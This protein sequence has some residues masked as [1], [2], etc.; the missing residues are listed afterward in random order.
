MYCTL[1]IPI[2]VHCTCT[3]HPCPYQTLARD[4]S[5]APFCKITV[6]IAIGGALALTAAR[7]GTSTP[8]TLSPSRYSHRRPGDPPLEPTRL[9]TSNKLVV[10]DGNASVTQSCSAQSSGPTN[11]RLHRTACRL[12]R[13]GGRGMSIPCLERGSTLVRPLAH[14]CMLCLSVPLCLALSHPLSLCLALSH[15]LSL[16]LSVP[17]SHPLSLCLALPQRASL[18]RSCL[19]S[20]SHQNPEPSVWV[21]AVCGAASCQRENC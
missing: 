19:A 7:L 4:P 9:L 8:S 6:G 21:A 17:L 2:V 10:K 20:N 1:V 14:T 15:P 5:T 12:H 11:D 3:E 18:P 16:C 13:T